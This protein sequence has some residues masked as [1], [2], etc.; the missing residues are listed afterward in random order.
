MHVLN[1]ISIIPADLLPIKQ[2]KYTV[3]WGRTTFCHAHKFDQQFASVAFRDDVEVT[4]WVKVAK[5][6]CENI[7]H[8]GCEARTQEVIKR[9][10]A[11]CGMKS[12]SNPMQ[13]P[14]NLDDVVT[15]IGDPNWHKA[16]TDSERHTMHLSLIHI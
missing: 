4:E 10:S 13:A 8:I 5:N 7:K 11:E 2:S 15:F 6:M 14:V 3:E 16:N 12:P 1:G 9:A